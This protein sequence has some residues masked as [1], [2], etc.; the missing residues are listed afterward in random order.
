MLAADRRAA[1]GLQPQDLARQEF[2]WRF[3]IRRTIGT[4][5]GAHRPARQEFRAHF[6]AGPNGLMADWRSLAGNFF[7][8]GPSRARKTLGK[9]VRRRIASTLFG[10]IISVPC[11]GRSCVR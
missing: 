10:A 1:T 7:A 5:F 2:R 4:W 11:A 8:G 6:R 3:V 9:R